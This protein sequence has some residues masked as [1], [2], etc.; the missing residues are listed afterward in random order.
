MT[1]PCFDYCAKRTREVRSKCGAHGGSQSKASFQQIALALG[2]G[3]ASACL[4]FGAQVALAPNPRG[5]WM[6]ADFYQIWAMVRALGSGLSPY[7]VGCTSIPPCADPN[8]YYP[9][10]AGLAV[11]PLGALSPV[12][13]AMAFAG[14]SAALLAYAIVRD[15]SRHAPLL[16]SY[17]FVIA[18]I[19]GQWAPLLMAASLIPGAEWL[20]AA[21]PQ[22]GLAL[23]VTRPRARALLLTIAFLIASLVVMP[24]WPLE[25]W[26]SAVGSRFV[27]SP[28]LGFA[29]YGPVLLLAGLRWRTREGRLLLALSLVPQTPFCYDQLLLWFVARTHRESLNLTWLSW[30]MFAAWYVF[31]APRKEQMIQLAS[32]APYLIAFLFVPCLAMVLLRTNEA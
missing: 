10:T 23:F 9:V 24:G 3:V 32:F 14:L 5:P 20:Y 28:A 7:A 16:L 26:H 29:W 18:I 8:Q 12:L 15:G 30:L 17:P 4:F 31:E 13:A 19:S 27:R 11:W 2:V 22:L 6:G 21:K 1:L 25:W